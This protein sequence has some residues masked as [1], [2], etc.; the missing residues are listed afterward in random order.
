MMTKPGNVAW[1]LMAEIQYL[2]QHISKLEG[3]TKII[4]SHILLIAFLLLISQL[5]VNKSY[6]QK[7]KKKEKETL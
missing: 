4:K 3:T 1:E 6:L 5:C 2:G 7:R